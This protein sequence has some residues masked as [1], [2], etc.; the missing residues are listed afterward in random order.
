[1]MMDGFDP[2]PSPSTMST[3]GLNE[4]RGVES[5]LLSLVHAAKGGDAADA[6]LVLC[7]AVLTTFLVLAT[8]CVIRLQ[9]RFLHLRSLFREQQLRVIMPEGKDERRRLQ[10]KKARERDEAASPSAEHDFAAEDE[11]A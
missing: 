3:G 7:V 2:P 4:N 1:M 11:S 6:T 9:W 8:C 5:E 10:S